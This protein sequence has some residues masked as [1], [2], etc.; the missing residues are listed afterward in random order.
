MS[1]QEWKPIILTE[2]VYIFKYWVETIEK[3][4][5]CTHLGY[6]CIFI[7]EYVQE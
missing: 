2:T 3:Q 7:S 4:C 5:V 6:K 1:H